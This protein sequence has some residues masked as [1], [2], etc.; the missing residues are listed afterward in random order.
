MFSSSKN[1]VKIIII[2]IVNKAKSYFFLYF[3]KTDTSSFMFP[4][5]LA[6]SKKVEVIENV[7]NVLYFLFPFFDK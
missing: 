2:N 6:R 4:Y 3:C 7:R 1:S 5:L